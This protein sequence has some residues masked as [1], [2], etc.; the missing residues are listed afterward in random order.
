MS[1]TIGIHVKKQADGWGNDGCNPTGTDEEISDRLREFLKERFPLGG[2]S[3]VSARLSNDDYGFDVGMPKYSSEFKGNG[4]ELK[5]MY[6]ALTDF[7]LDNFSMVHG[8]E[9]RMYWS[10]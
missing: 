10:G 2:Y 3:Y 9:M 8:I 6:L 7:A 5:Q 4:Y 1:L